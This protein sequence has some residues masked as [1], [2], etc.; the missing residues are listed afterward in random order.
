MSVSK[1][2]TPRVHMTRPWPVRKEEGNYGFVC[3]PTHPEI[4]VFN[5]PTD[6]GKPAYP[7]SLGGGRQTSTPTVA[8][9]PTSAK[10]DANY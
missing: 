2:F 8:K 3:P 9:R 6:S 7:L 5:A 10:K 1:L 4:S